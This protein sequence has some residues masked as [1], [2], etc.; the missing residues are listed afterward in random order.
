MQNGY[1]QLSRG[2]MSPKYVCAP[3]PVFYHY[4]CN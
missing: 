4:S 3:V 2:C 1:T